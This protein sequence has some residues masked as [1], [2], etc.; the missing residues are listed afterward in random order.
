MFIIVI[1]KILAYTDDQL[2]YRS[3]NNQI[4]HIMLKLVMNHVH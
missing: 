3:I 1:E 2:N 4:R